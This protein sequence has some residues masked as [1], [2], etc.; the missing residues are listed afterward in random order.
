M[1][2]GSPDEGI[3]RNPLDSF[4]DREHIL[5]K[6][7]QLLRST[8]SGEFRLLAIKGNSGTGKTFLLEYLSK[9]VC[10]PAAWQIGTLAFA[11]SFPD[12][13]TIL[14]SLEDTFKLC[15]SRES[16]K[17]YRI[18][19]D[20]YKR[21]FDEYRAIITV[22][23]HLDVREAASASNI[24]M[25][26]TVNAELRRRELQLRAELTRA[27]LELAEECEHPLCLFIDGYERLV[28][29]DAELTNWLW[30]EV[31]L[32]LPKHTMHPLLIV[33]CGWEYPL[34][35]ALQPFSIY[36]ELGDFDEL[37]VKDYLRAQGVILHDIAIQD[38]LVRAF[39]TLSQGHPLVLSLA[40]AYFQTLPM[41]E[42]TPQSLHTHSPL[43]TEDARVQWLEERLLKRLPEPYRTLLERGPILRSFD[44]ATLNV[45]L[46]VKGDEQDDVP[47]LDDR[48]YAQFLNY[49]FIN[50]KNVQGD[51][52]LMFPTFHNLARRVRI[53]TLRRLH[54]ETKQRLHHAI[55]VYYKELVEA[56]QQHV[57]P[58]QATGESSTYA[59]WFAEL[60][61]Q[62]FCAQ[63]ELLYHAL[64]V[65]EM[66]R[67]TFETW[68]VLTSQAL[69]KWERKQALQLLEV[70]KQ[71][72]EEDDPFLNEQSDVYGQYL[73]RY[74]RFLEQE[75]R[76]DEAL[77]DLKEAALVFER[78]KNI[79][80]RAVCL[81]NIGMIY[82]EQGKFT[83]ALDYQKRALSL[84]EQI[85][86]PAPIAVSL[87]NIGT[88]YCLQGQ[89]LH[90]LNYYQRALS[91]QKQVSNAADVAL[92]LNNIGT[93]YDLQGQFTHALNYY[94]QAL[95]LSERMSNSAD[96]A[97]SL[98]NIGGIYYSRGQLALALD[99]YQ[100][101]LSLQEQISN[102][103]PIA[104]SL[105]NIG[106]IYHLQGQLALALD[107]YQ[108]A[109]SLREQIGNPVE[110]ALCLNNIGAVYHLQGQLAHALNYYE[111][112]RTLYQQAGAPAGIG[113]SLN[114]IGFIYKAQ[115]Q[116]AI[117]LDYYQR[118]LALY[119][120]LSASVEIALSLNNIGTIYD[121]QGQ[122]AHA[123]KYYGCAL[124]LQ[125]QI[126]NPADIAVSLHNIGS[127]YNVKE[128]W[129]DAVSLFL[130]A[131]TLYE[132]MGNGFESNVANELEMVAICYLKLG[133]TEKGAEYEARAKQIREQLWQS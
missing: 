4:I 31:L 13:R 121:A 133:E 128:Q 92:F 111:R 46:S 53:E 89:L 52:L 54:P 42:R 63:V 50:R 122:L 124:A 18:Q 20:S 48:A 17:S 26:A 30:E 41:S 127:I 34:S 78:K 131:V 88:I 57:T 101:A 70:V 102:P 6:F 62:A 118:A 100:R 25:N 106:L 110:I 12:F 8:Q 56:E 99:Y 120:Q 69:N 97:G 82:K 93:I 77:I 95:V 129:P 119:R 80:E 47:T 109:L 64:Q 68:R 27:L 76:W 71:V 79:S 9:R 59:A 55:V 11:Q 14:D 85:G 23:L 45:L 21:S 29:T 98:N 86:N 60:S 132:Q 125:E 37:R 67:E 84:E 3:V 22:N 33:T 39:Y 16:L 10:P 35:S 91:L 40:V 44:Q 116:L 113:L 126:G 38:P 114:N 130:R 75:S 32:N 105:N 28:E 81:N 36:D 43:I 94:Q 83:D 65:K 72:V 115:G 7:R 108:R 96:V 49:P 19:R 73:V 117:A 103:A 66:Q 61:E 58:F 90:A 24:Q 2:I 74:A 5:T 107:Y 15:V 1:A 87:N 104:V 112:A 123:L 51:T